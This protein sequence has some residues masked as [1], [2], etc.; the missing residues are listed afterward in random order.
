MNEYNGA[1]AVKTTGIVNV[2]FGSVDAPNLNPAQAVIERGTNSY[3]KWIRVDFYGGTF[4][5]IS[6]IKVW[7]SD[8]QFG[9]GPVLPSG[10]WVKGEAGSSSDL[11]YQ[12]PSRV[13]RVTQDLPRLKSEAL[14]VGPAQLTT[15]GESY[16]I[17]LQLVTTTDA[18]TGDVDLGYIAVEWQEE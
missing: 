12:Q 16:F 8:G 1:G 15:Y 17:H 14:S 9:D 2:N 10:V 7:R 18:P 13:Q 6:N 11:T 5:R 4:N 3:D